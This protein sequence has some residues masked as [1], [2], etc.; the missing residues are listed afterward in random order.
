MNLDVVQFGVEI[1]SAQ[2]HQKYAWF[3]QNFAYRIPNVKRVIYYEHFKG[4]WSRLKIGKSIVQLSLQ[5]IRA[6]LRPNKKAPNLPWEVR[7]NWLDCSFELTS[8]EPFRLFETGRSIFGTAEMT[9]LA[10]FSRVELHLRSRAE[11]RLLIK[12]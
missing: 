12:Y 3:W 4:H 6:S 11:S 10:E 9:C 7:C 1:Y 5:S 2:F 8:T